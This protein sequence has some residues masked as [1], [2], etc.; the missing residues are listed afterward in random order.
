MVKD[1]TGASDPVAILRV[2]KQ[3]ERSAIITADVNPI[4]E[5]TFG[6]ECSIS[7]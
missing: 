7:G 3:E 6:F 5:E 2:G 4:W 1:V